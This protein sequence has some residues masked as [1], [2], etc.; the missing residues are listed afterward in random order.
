MPTY[1][2]LLFAQSG[3]GVPS[4]RK[5]VCVRHTEDVARLFRVSADFEFHIIIEQ[6]DTPQAQYRNPKLA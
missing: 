2:I 4:S 3:E 5:G 6:I 1:E